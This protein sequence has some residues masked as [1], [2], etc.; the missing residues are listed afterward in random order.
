M[1][2]NQ[3]GSNGL[4]S[5]YR[6]TDI[7][8]GQNPEAPADVIKNWLRSRTTIE[9]LGLADEML[10]KLNKIAVYQMNSLLSNPPKSID[11]IKQIDSK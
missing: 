1:F 4:V 3:S 7:A 11:N 2:K 5:L 6:H 10:Y 8:K 9:F